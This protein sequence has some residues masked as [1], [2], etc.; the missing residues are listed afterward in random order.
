MFIVSRK[1]A[2]VLELYLLT[3]FIEPG[4]FNHFDRVSLTL[5]RCAPQPVILPVPPVSLTT[6][7][8]RAVCR[9]PPCIMGS[10]FPTA[11][12]I[13]SWTPTA[14]AEVGPIFE[15]L[16]VGCLSSPLSLPPSLPQLLRLVLGSR[17][18]PVHLLSWYTPPPPGSVCGDMWGGALLAGPDLPK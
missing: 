10:A 16:K 11:Q 12:I 3:F 14:D 4:V 9:G 2:G 5:A 18:I 13:I 17:S 8:A 7:G 1:V 6:P 15:L